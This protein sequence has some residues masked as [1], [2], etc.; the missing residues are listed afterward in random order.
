MDLII[1]NEPERVVN[2]ELLPFAEAGLST[3]HHLLEFDVIANHH[4]VT[5]VPRVVYN[6]KASDFD[7]LR[8]AILNCVNSTNC[9]LDN[10]DVDSCWLQWKTNL[11]RLVDLQIPKIT[12]RDA[13]TPPCIDKVVR[14][15]LKKEE[16]ARRAAKKHPDSVRFLEKLLPKEQPKSSPKLLPKEV[17]TLI[18]TKQKEYIESLGDSLKENPKRLWNY[19]RSKTK[20]NSIPANVTY[21]DKT[22]VSG[23][24]K[25]DAFNRFFFSTFTQD[26]DSSGVT[27]SPPVLGTRPLLECLQILFSI[28][29]GGSLLHWLRSYL[30][31]RYQRTVV[32]GYTSSSLP[33]VSG[34]PQGSILG[35]VLFLVYV[36]DLPSVVDCQVALFADDSKCVKVINSISDC[37]SLQDDLDNVSCWSKDW[38]LRFNSTKCEILS[39]GRKRSPI[40]HTYKLD[41]NPLKHVKQEKDLGILVTKME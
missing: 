15:L 31:G 21:S 29:I 10:P 24:E 20:S 36:N 28:F 37:Y 38:R 14:H 13:N 18:N 16:S 35:P 12:I 3:D 23:L 19:Y 25:A 5:K 30:L 32:H 40:V 9:A 1:A 22:F 41:N 7:N 27:L 6:F 11:L 8:S 26:T 2:I 17:K 39:V 33:V 34:M 4:S